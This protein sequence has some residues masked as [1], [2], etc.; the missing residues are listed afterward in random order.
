M[1]GINSAKLLVRAERALRN[2]LSSVFSPPQQFQCLMLAGNA[3]VSGKLPAGSTPVQQLAAVR[4]EEVV[5]RLTHSLC[6]EMNRRQNQRIELN[7]GVLTD[8]QSVMKLIAEDLDR[9]E[10]DPDLIFL[11]DEGLTQ[12]VN[13]VVEDN[14]STLEKI[15]ERELSEVVQKS[16][17]HPLLTHRNEHGEWMYEAVVRSAWARAVAFVRSGAYREALMSFISEDSQSLKYP[18]FRK[19]IFHYVQPVAVAEATESPFPNEVLLGWQVAGEDGHVAF[20]R[21]L[22]SH[23]TWCSR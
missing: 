19:T 8:S 7:G 20:S 13:E 23:W 15:V 16:C 6:A 10:S 3:F 21:P 17:D 1:D 14:Q 2:S 11:G 4:V 18:E 22:I 5:V 9:H 12:L